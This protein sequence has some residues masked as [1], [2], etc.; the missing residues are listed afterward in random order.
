MTASDDRLVPVLLCSSV[1]RQAAASAPVLGPVGW[2][3][4]EQRL[5]RADLPPGALLTM[6]PDELKAGLG[7]NDEQTTRLAA[8]LRRAGPTAIELERLADRGLWFMVTVDA[9]Y[10]P[11]LRAALRATAPPV[12]F[13]AGE[14][15]LL[16]TSSVAVVG[17]RDASDESMLFAAQLGRSA[18]AGG[19][20]IASG[21]AR[22]ID[23]EATNGALSAS[24][25]AVAVVAEQ[26]DRRVRDPAARTAIGERRL[27]LVSPYAPGAGFSVRGAM[28]RNKIVYGLGEVAVVVTAKENQGG[29]WAG[30]VEALRGQTVPVFVRGAA[31]SGSK[32]LVALGAHMIPWPAP[33]DTLSLADFAVRSPMP[34]DAG[35]QQDTLFGPPESVA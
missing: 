13:G 3:D 29:T 23:A 9:D 10:P 1:G 15:S 4:L 30:A 14:R 34:P 21:G 26:L 24:G 12:L 25:T 33:P 2:S 6:R 20:T 35:A 8:L 5:K 22:G 7:L 19:L 27:A 16:A 28:G 31:D 18:A 11:R 17:S 32:A